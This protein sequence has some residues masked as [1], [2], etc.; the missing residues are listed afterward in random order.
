MYCFIRR[1]SAPTVGHSYSKERIKELNAELNAEL[2]ENKNESKHTPNDVIIDK[3][4]TNGATDAV[5]SVMY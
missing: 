1:S 3:A 5:S 2:D 4:D